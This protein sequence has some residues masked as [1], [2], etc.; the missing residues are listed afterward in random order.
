MWGGLDN[1]LVGWDCLRQYGTLWATLVKF[2]V[3]SGKIPEG[4][5]KIP[6]GIFQEPLGIFLE[7]LGI[8]VP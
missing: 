4:S 2:G 7:S 5:G 6:E 8:F 1:P 3:G